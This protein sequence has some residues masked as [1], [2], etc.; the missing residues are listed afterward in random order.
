MDN[1]N[2]KSKYIIDFIFF[3]FLFLTT[4]YA[5]NTVTSY[6]FHILLIIP[7]GL[8]LVLCLLYHLKLKKLSVFVLFLSFSIWILMFSLINN[9]DIFYA[10]K[11]LITILFSCIIVQ[12]YDFQTFRKLFVK[13]M[14]IISI[15]SLIGFIYLF[16]CNFSPPFPIVTNVTGVKYYNAY[17]FF[18]IVG[19]AGGRNLGCFWEPGIFGSFLLLAITF[20]VID[21]EKP[22][23]F[24]I[25]IL[26]AALLTTQSTAAYILSLLIVLLFFAKNIST[27]KV[28]DILLC[29]LFFFVFFVVLV[30]S[31]SIFNYLLKIQPRVFEKL[32]TDNASSSARQESPF[33]N[34][35]IFSQYPVFGAGIGK[36]SNLYSSMTSA[37]QTSTSTFLLAAFGLLG[38]IFT[39]AQFFGI[40]FYKKWDFIT[41]IIV[42]VLFFSI[43]NKEPHT[44]FTITWAISF[45]FI[46]DGFSSRR[47]R[48][49]G[50]NF[51]GKKLYCENKK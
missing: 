4:G 34:L 23:L 30:Y 29:I 7:I 24:N 42:L 3:L 20:H 49:G 8:F 16:F 40:L 11:F 14:M 35:S 2:S 41:R 37:S 10:I 27:F 13:A 15:I 17:F 46:S 33:I 47:D 22:K 19:A 1:I 28:K 39:A 38:V 25:I 36:A 31:E 50:E 6:N 21:N 44:F 9:D 12:L 32:V 51:A 43:L 45:Y 48:S 26:F 18:D 5:L